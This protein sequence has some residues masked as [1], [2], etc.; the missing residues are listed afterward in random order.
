MF[1]NIATWKKLAAWLPSLLRPYPVHPS[2][3]R[4]TAFPEFQVTKDPG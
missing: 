4:V 1:S 3:D 2:D